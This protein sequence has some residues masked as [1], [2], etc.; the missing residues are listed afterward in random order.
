ML[1]FALAFSLV[2]C[3]KTPTKKPIP[4]TPS[5]ESP[6]EDNNSDI[7]GVNSDLLGEIEDPFIDSIPDGNIDT[8]ID[9][10]D[11]TEFEGEF[12]VLPETEYSTK[13]PD[14]DPI[15]DGDEM[16]ELGDIDENLG[17]DRLTA[18]S[19]IQKEGEHVDGKDREFN[20]DVTN[21]VY[22]DF[23]GLGSNVF[24]TN[25][26]EEAY[27]KLKS[28][29]S[30]D[31]DEVNFEIDADRW[32][33]AKSHYNRMW[34]DIH[35]FTT[36]E[37]KDPKR[38]DIENNKDYQNYLNGI[39]DYDSDYM[40]SVYK[41]LQVWQDSGSVTALNYCW[42]VGERIQEW[43]SLPDVSDPS[44]SAPFDLD[45]Y[46]RS[47]VDLLEYLRNEKGFTSIECLT[48]Y[49]EPNIGDFTSYIDEPA[50]WVAMV[51]RVGEELEKRNLRD[52]IELWGTEHS[53]I[54]RTSHDF[55]EYVR[56]HGSEYFDSWAFHSYYSTT[57]E[58]RE[59]DYSYWYHFWSYMNET[60]GKR[61][62]VSETYAA[63]PTYG[64]TFEENTKA[65]R[66]WNS[67]LG[68]QIVCVANVGLYGV[69]NWGMTGGYIPDPVGFTVCDT[70]DAAWNI[71]KNDKH[72]DSVQH[73]FFDES[74]ITNYIPSHSDVL[75][76]DWTGDDIHGAAFKLPDGGYSILIDAA[77]NID[78][79]VGTEYEYKETSER[80]ITFN[81]SG[82]P[83]DVTFYRYSY[84]P[85]DQHLNQHATINTSDRKIK[86]KDGVFKDTVDKDY[87]MY[88]YTTLPPVK[89]IEIDGESVLHKIEKGTD[90]YSFS[91]KAIDCTGDIV[92]SISAA[93]DGARNSKMDKCGTIDNNGVY[94]PDKD[95]KAGD[96]IAIR[97]SLKSNPKI[98]DTVVIR[99]VEN[100]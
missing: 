11:G 39:Y 31:Y 25:L 48:F 10:S 73:N 28:S 49:N 46:A 87:G 56:D 81:L 37:E 22:A 3:K 53:S 67:S 80:D 86:T 50:Y 42:K 7:D 82:L 4:S 97:A 72:L 17:V 14:A 52:K 32:L 54:Q 33:A 40:Q 19:L 20:I 69:L 68:S 38:Q 36:S 88:I 65:W 77:G 71:I 41:Y 26:T 47:C 43:F 91:A 58:Q 27:N 84:D 29:E 60:Y 74:L 99:I 51:K 13:S 23:R 90:S 18:T 78:Q 66:S 64:P 8:E 34:F 85:D 61:T 21:V 24:P 45:A 75:M 6:I 2:S 9:I 95:A 89:Q 83:K 55:P 62:Y 16:G 92:W 93:T 98:H 1:A 57:P 12:V 96:K 15:I 94:K 100:N 79:T 76:V 30:W 59:N 70:A 44:T 35:W 63:S 5:G